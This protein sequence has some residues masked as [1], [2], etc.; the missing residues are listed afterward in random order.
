M[1]ANGPGATGQA[2]EA[3]VQTVA[4]I[5]GD[6]NRFT[7]KQVTVRGEV[8]EVYGR[9]GFKLDDEALTKGGV[10]DDL[11]VLGAKD[12]TWDVN[13]DWGKTA[14][15]VTGTLRRV[16]GAKLEKELGWQPESNVSDALEGETVALVA[17]NVQRTED[18]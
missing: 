15:R 6:P 2:A 4:D 18:R 8:E 16:S 7:G 5:T 13:D 3:N 9:R 12:A 14:V 17:D 11:I 1:Q 10:D